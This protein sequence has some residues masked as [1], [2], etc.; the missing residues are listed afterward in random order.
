M[1]E[2]NGCNVMS[3]DAISASLADNFGLAFD[4]FSNALA[5]GH[6]ADGLAPNFGSGKR[7]FHDGLDVLGELHTRDTAQASVP[8][9][10][11]PNVV[12]F[13]ADDLHGVE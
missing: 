7:E 13:A 9:V 1:A 3:A 4:K 2:L 6:E 10:S 11:L 12:R 8:D 5:S